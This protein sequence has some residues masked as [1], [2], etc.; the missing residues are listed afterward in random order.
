M[1]LTS[2]RSSLGLMVVRLKGYCK[3][4]L[5]DILRSHVYE[6]FNVTA[7][8]EEVLEYVCDLATHGDYTGYCRYALGLLHTSGLIAD[9]LK[10]GT[11]LVDHIR[12][13]V[14]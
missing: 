4:E 8:P 9:E 10:S 5:R 2:E 3:K 6:A 12:K 1:F 11:V 14:S 7:V 13:A